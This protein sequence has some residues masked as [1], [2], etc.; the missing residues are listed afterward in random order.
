MPNK[1]L[2]QDCPEL[3]VACRLARQAGAVVLEHYNQGCEVQYKDAQCSDPVTQADTD[4]NDIIV[5]GL[6]KA[7]PEDGILAEESTDTSQRRHCKRL[8]CVDPLDGTR[9]FVERSDQFVVMIGLAVDEEACLGVVYQ[10][11]TDIL[12]WGVDGIA[13]REAND[14]P[15]QPLKVSANTDPKQAIMVVSRSR[16]TP[17]LEELAKTLQVQQLFPLGSVGL[18]VAQIAEATADIYASL[19]S[20]TKEWDTCGPEA[21]I[22]AAGGALTDTRGRPLRYNKTIPDT[23]YGM[24]GSNQVVHAKVVEAVAPIISNQG[25][26]LKFTEE[27]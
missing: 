9:D 20:R 24:L 16:R 27:G 19:T 25:P 11:T 13:C 15:P 18:K 23:P 4:A 1:R 3:L 8:W 5:A 17:Q 6:E 10:P 14:D 2:T 26:Q 7:F 22:K 21:I 12:W